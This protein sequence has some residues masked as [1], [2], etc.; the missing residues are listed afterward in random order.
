M[1]TPK[2]AAGYA[3]D[4]TEDNR[5]G[6]MEREEAMMKSFEKHPSENRIFSTKKPVAGK[7]AI[8]AEICET[9]VGQFV[10]PITR[11]TNVENKPSML[12]KLSFC[13]P[14]G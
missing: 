10:I 11:E 7:Y 4:A 5:K 6:A 8:L 14:K 13:D 9:F 2:D 12:Q 3:A 1:A